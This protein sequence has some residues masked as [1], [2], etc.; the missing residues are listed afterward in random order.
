MATIADWRTLAASKRESLAAKI[1]TEWRLPNSILSQISQSSN[2]CVLDIPKTCGILT[3]RELD[4]TER[5]DATALVEMMV[6]KETTSHEVTMAFCKRTAIAQQVTNCCT[7]I[8]FDEALERA[9]EC[10]SYLATNGAPMGPVHGLPISLKV[11]IFIIIRWTLYLFAI[12]YFILWGLFRSIRLPG[13]V[14]N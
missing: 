14:S 8:M 13:V 10:D 5:Y 12:L 9:K 1:P 2:I 6:K 11:T 3:E 4:L 7:E